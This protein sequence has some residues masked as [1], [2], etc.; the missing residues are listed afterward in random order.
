MPVVR[1]SQR[2]AY[3]PGAVNIGVVIG[4]SGRCA[5]IDTGLN[6]TSAKKALKAIAADIGLTVSLVLTTHAHADHFGGNATVVKRTGAEVWA[7]PIDEAILRNPLLQPSLL[8]GGADPPASLRGGFLLAE[9]SP[10]DR[11]LTD[12]T[13]D[14]DGVPIDVVPL[15]GHSP[16]Q[17]GFLIDGTFFCADVVLPGTVLDKYKVPYLYSVTDHLRSLDFTL[18]IQCSRAVPGHGD[19]S[20][21]IAPAVF[22]NQLLVHQVADCVLDLAPGPQS[23][24][25]LLIG[26][27]DR[28]DAPIA[29]AGS[30]FLLQPTIYAFL[31]YLESTGA[32]S[33][34]IDGKRLLWKRI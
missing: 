3:I 27:L 21:S 14:F 22:A 7:P 8:F 4:D 1:I 5:L 33:S 31:S 11:V 18:T 17:V 30:Y 29:D 20:D 10:V 13:V 16:G 15:P 34:Q 26:V 28:F 23:A 19:V 24:E 9:A 2:V 12:A 6:D 25:S 32:I